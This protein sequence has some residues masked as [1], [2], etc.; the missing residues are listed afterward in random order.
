MEHPLKAG[1]AGTI[2]K[3]LVQAGDQVKGRQKLIQITAAATE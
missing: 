3:V 1:V 2:A